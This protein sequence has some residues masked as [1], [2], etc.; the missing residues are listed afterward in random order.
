[1]VKRKVNDT[2]IVIPEADP[3]EPLKPKFFG[4]QTHRYAV[5]SAQT[6]SRLPEEVLENPKLWAFVAP[7]L[8]VGD[9]V[10]VAAD[11]CSFVAT[12][13]CTFVQGSDARMRV[14]TYSE[15]D[16]VDYNALTATSDEYRVELC[17][18]KKW[19]IVKAD[20][21]FIQDEIATQAKAMQLLQDY[22]QALVA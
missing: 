22:V 16:A 2:P 21:T 8:K 4:L 15:L 18:M 6:P 13:F 3:V 19:C 12:L 9:E 7:R 20:G 17:G 11:D 1:M 5:H 14:L 10:R